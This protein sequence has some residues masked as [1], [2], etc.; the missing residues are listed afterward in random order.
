MTATV[1]LL[2]I[3]QPNDNA[4]QDPGSTRCETATGIIIAAGK[5]DSIMASGHCRK[6]E[7]A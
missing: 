7:L 6:E 4:F 2:R 3:G 1:I 5:P